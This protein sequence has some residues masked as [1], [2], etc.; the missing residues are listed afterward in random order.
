MHLTRLKFDNKN[1]F[2]RNLIFTK[3]PVFR[4][5]ARIFFLRTGMVKFGLTWLENVLRTEGYFVSEALDT[6]KLAKDVRARLVENDIPVTS[7][8]VD[9]MLFKLRFKPQSLYV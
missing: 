8:I 4:Q 9:G 6:A 3:T 7:F 1:G 5:I 2:N